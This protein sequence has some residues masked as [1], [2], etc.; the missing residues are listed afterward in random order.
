[1]MRSYFHGTGVLFTALIFFALVVHPTTAQDL[2]SE[3]ALINALRQ[4]GY[5]IYF[6]HAATDWSQDD[7]VM[8]EGDWTSCDPEKMRQLSDE[9]REQARRIGKA[10]RRLNIPV[11]Q[12]LS[13]EYCRARETAALMNL[14]PVKP[15]RAL[16]NMRI[17]GMTGGR[18]AVIE[19]ARQEIGRRPKEGTNRVLVAHGNLMR[20]ATGEY[21]GEAGAAVF[22]PNGDDAF[23][24]I[25]R[26]SY[27]YWVHLA[28]RYAM[29]P[30]DYTRKHQL[31]LDVHKS[32]KPIVQRLSCD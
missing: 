3:E 19:R 7:R 8:A 12:V 9:G 22:A 27:E 20:A 1:M 24:L 23:T 2:L 13:S 25:A 21:T 14:G 26:I 18:N 6:R 10:I 30:S 11:D 15:T 16:M 17:A 5:T 28:E 32:I 4:G 29:Y 31:R